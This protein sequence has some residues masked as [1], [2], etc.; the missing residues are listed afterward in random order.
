MKQEV[1]KVEEEDEKEEEEEEKKK[2]KKTTKT[3]TT[4]T[5]TTKRGNLECRHLAARADHT[6]RRVVLNPRTPQT[7][8]IFIVIFPEIFEQEDALNFSVS[9]CQGQHSFDISVTGNQIISTVGTL[10]TAN[11]AITAIGFIRVSLKLRRNGNDEFPCGSTPKNRK[12][13]WL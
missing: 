13:P 12:H 7:L 4:T 2:K 8:S 6:R 9:S 11:N 3:K 5:T 10:T 1:E